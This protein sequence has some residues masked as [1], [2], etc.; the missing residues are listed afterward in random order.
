M[1]LKCFNR[2]SNSMENHEALEG[3]RNN[4]PVDSSETIEYRDWNLAS[5]KI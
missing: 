4:T 5:Y 3:E 2:L 1:I